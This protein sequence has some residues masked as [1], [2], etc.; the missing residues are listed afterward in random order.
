MKNNIFATAFLVMNM[1]CFAQDLKLKNDQIVYDKVPV[2]NFIKEKRNFNLSSLENTDLITAEVVR[3]ELS[4]KMYLDLTQVATQ[5]K[6]Q[7]PMEAYSAMNEKKYVSLA[8]EKAGFVNNK[9]FQKDFINSYMSGQKFDY[10]KE[11]GCTDLLEGQEK[12]KNLNVIV[13][14][15]GKITKGQNTPV[16]SIY[17]SISLDVIKYEVHKY[18]LSNPQGNS[19]ATA[20]GTKTGGYWTAIM[21]TSDGKEFKVPM[22]EFFGFDYTCDKD[23]NIEMMLLILVQNGYSL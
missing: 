11:Y 14:K 8:F 3:C 21:T 23:K 2:A 1:F 9:G 12:L 6:N 20:V 13:L 4:G 7:L 16:G 17:R 22:K 15:N 19:I 5:A 10:A 18:T